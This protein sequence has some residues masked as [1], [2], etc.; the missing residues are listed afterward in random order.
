MPNTHSG[1]ILFICWICYG[2]YIPLIGTHNI[3]TVSIH[4]MAGYG[5]RNCLGMTHFFGKILIGPKVIQGRKECRSGFVIPL[6]DKIFSDLCT[7]DKCSF[8]GFTFGCA[9]STCDL[10]HVL[11]DSTCYINGVWCPP[12]SKTRS[13]VLTRIC[14][15]INSHWPP[16]TLHFQQAS[17]SSPTP[18][19]T[20]CKTFLITSFK[21]FSPHISKH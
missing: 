4:N 2:Y 6:G 17:Q 12:V 7:W 19:W 10:I 14:R 21:A 18:T 15:H 11:D 5:K 3:Y 1:S 13:S 9:S 16:L 8:T 20:L